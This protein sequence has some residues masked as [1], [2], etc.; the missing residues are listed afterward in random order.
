MTIVMSYYIVNKENYPPEYFILVKELLF[1]IFWKY[2]EFLFFIQF[3]YVCF[4]L[5]SLCWGLRCVCPLISALTS[6]YL[7][8]TQLKGSKKYQILKFELSYKYFIPFFFWC[9]FLTLWIVFES[10][11]LFYFFGINSDIF[12]FHWILM[13]KEDLSTWHWHHFHCLLILL[14]INVKFSWWGQAH[15]TWSMH[16]SWWLHV[17]QTCVTWPWSHFYGILTL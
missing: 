5:N 17:S 16:W 8:L 6:L 10:I 14:N 9:K 7:I 3:W 11:I 12:T 2:L 1:D 13:Q 15:H 4:P